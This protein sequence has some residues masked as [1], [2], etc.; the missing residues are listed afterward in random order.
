MFWKSHLN[1]LAC[2]GSPR[3]SSLV[4][5]QVYQ[6]G[7]KSRD[8]IAL[9]KQLRHE[10][11]ILHQVI[12]RSCNIASVITRSYGTCTFIVDERGLQV[13]NNKTCR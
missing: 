12:A 8:D 11:A 2:L 6:A 7:Y 9:H 1:H 3:E 4:A 10:H 5:K 13:H